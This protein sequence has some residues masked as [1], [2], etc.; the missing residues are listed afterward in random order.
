MSILFGAR[1]LKYS[2][3]GLIGIRL[4]FSVTWLCKE[5]LQF[6]KYLSNSFGFCAAVINNFLLNRYWT[7]AG[8]AHPFTEQLVKFVLVAVTGLLINN[9]ILYLLVKNLR[10]IF[11]F[12]KLIVIGLVFSCNYIVNFIFTFN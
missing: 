3:V 11:Y 2:Q 1:L 7:F 5:K 12:L 8:T 10:R 6:N 9:I 4:D